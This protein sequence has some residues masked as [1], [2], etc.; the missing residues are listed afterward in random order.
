MVGVLI[1]LPLFAAAVAAVIRSNRLRPWVLPP[2]AAAHASLTLW[3]LLHPNAVEVTRWL[4]LDPPGRIVL[5]ILST[6]F[7]VCAVYSVGYLRYRLELSNRIFCVGLL[8]FLS[9]TTL[10]SC[11]RHLGLMWVAIEA[12]TLAT[13]PLIYFNR[14][15]RSIEATWKYL[16][17]GSVG[18][19]MALLGSFFLAYAAIQKGVDSSLLFQDLLRN[20]PLLS[21]PWLH[22]AF[23]LLLIGYGTKMGLAPMHTWKPDAYG[24]APGVIGALLAGGLTNCAFLA[25]LRVDHVCRAAGESVYTSQ[26]LIFMGVLSMAFAAVFVVAQRDFK[27]MLAYSSVEHMGIL[28]LGIG[29]GGGAV[30][31]SLLHMINNGLTKGVLFLSAGNIHR[32]FD[33]KSADQVQGAIRRLPLSGTLFLLGFFAITGSPPFGPFI[34]EFTILNGAFSSGRFLVAA[35]FLSLLLIIFIGMGRTVL[36]IVQGRPSAA[37]RR[38]AYR[39]GLLTGLPILATFAVVLL[40][41][42][43]IPSPLANLLHD[44]VRYLEVRP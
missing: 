17:I 22:A 9:A 43:Y 19:A 8:L 16:L 39:D 26:L 13:A 3:V 5:L 24:E 38:T 14:T 10:V 7:L 21:K 11:S 1:I 18:I 4:A 29:I 34:S 37:S 23:V 33:S 31:G 20:A 25:L 6:L 41:G 2:A 42:V 35:L 15:T 32:A 28:V 36:T 40:L 30:F 44:A 12:T 27:R